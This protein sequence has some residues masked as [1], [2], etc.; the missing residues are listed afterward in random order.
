MDIPHGARELEYE[1]TITLTMRISGYI[2]PTI[3]MSEDDIEGLIIERFMDTA[4][5]W[6]AE[7]HVLS[8]KELRW[9]S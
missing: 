9:R 5:L 7:S 4:E 6:D 2:E 1:G 8:L 3:D